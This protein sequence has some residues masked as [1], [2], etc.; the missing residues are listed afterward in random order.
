MQLFTPSSIPLLLV[1]L[2]LLSISTT[3]AAPKAS[4]PPPAGATPDDK[5]HPCLIRE[6]R[7][8]PKC[9]LLSPSTPALPSS[10]NN[11][12]VIQRYKDTYPD[13]V[14]CLCS[15][16]KWIEVEGGPQDWISRCNNVCTVAVFKNQKKIL[17][18]FQKRLSCDE[19]VGGGGSASRKSPP[20]AVSQNPVTPPVRKPAN[21]ATPALAPPAA[22]A[23]PEARPVSA[24][25]P[26]EVAA[27]KPDPKPA[28]KESA[29][30]T[31]STS[32][33]TP[34]TKGSKVGGDAKPAL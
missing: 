8:V 4:S 29:A 14:D 2:S 1:F 27:T 33:A 7:T 6:L 24:L 23:A 10:E 34:N 30:S 26:E 19:S 13:V 31:A 3:T 32:N 16:A 21:D 15:A 18:G 22:A 25:K 28:A 5:C 20:A 9:D 17:E 12:V 11:P